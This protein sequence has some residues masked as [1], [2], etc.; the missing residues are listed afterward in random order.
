MDIGGAEGGGAV[1]GMRDSKLGGGKGSAKLRL[2]Q[3]SNTSRIE[4]NE[5]TVS[6]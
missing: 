4:K 6:K 1:D 2:A 5:R 3:R